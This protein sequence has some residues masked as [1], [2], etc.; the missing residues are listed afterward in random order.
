MLVRSRAAFVALIAVFGAFVL[1]ACAQVEED[2][3]LHEAHG[4]VEAEVHDEHGEAGHDT[5]P[6]LG[7][8]TDLALWTLVTFLVFLFVLWKFAWQPLISGLDQRESRIRSDIV[9]AEDARRKAEA[10]LAD[11]EGR[12]E[13]AQEEVRG[14][15]A[16]ARRDAEVA[17]QNIISDAQREAAATQQR[18]VDEIERAK[19]QALKEL[20]DTLAAHV[21]LATEHVLGRSVTD[22][23]Q[24]RLIEE[25]LS[26]L[27]RQ[28]S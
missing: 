8:K 1:P 23:D 24:D 12:L 13:A 18:A 26:Q 6:P 15:L 11:Y 14:I 25:A 2:P 5:G 9:A 17:R 10:M 3:L 21:A 16:E 19:Q 27:A 20:S 22:H 4:D 7:W 28:S